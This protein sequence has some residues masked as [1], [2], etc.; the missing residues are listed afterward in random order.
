MGGVQYR[1][2]ILMITIEGILNVLVGG[3]QYCGY[4]NN[5]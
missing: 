4:S 5:N 3:V 2:G 1:G